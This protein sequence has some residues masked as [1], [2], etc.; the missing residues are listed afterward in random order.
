MDSFS[1]SSL[2]SSF[3]WHD[4]V[5]QHVFPLLGV[6]TGTFMS[7]AP[8]RAVLHATRSDGNLGDI[9]PTPWIFM[10]GNCCG[11]LT[12]SFITLNVYVFVTN[13]PG[14]ILSIWLNIQAI[15]LSYEN[16]RSNELQQAII[17]A[18]E[19]HSKKTLKKS[20]VE[21]I[22]TN[23]ITEEPIFDLSIID[24]AVT[25]PI[26]EDGV[27]VGESTDESSGTTTT[28]PSSSTYYSTETSSSLEEAEAAAAVAA[29]EVAEFKKHFHTYQ[30][31]NDDSYVDKNDNEYEDAN[32]FMDGITT[33]NEAA[34]MIVDYASFIWD[35]AAQKT[36]AP[37][38]HELMV[39]GIST[40]W[41]FLITVVVFTQQILDA[42]TRTLIIGVSVNLN[43]IFFYGAPLS[44]IVTV[45]DTKSSK[46]IHVPTMI[47]SLFNGTLWF[48]YG[49]AV[50][51]YFI[52]LPNGF[53]AML[54]VIQMIL[55]VLYP[56]HNRNRYH[57]VLSGDN[58]GIM[59]TK[60]QSTSSSS[61]DSLD[62]PEESTPLI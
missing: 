30:D 10:L 53:G 60:S 37:A 36:P 14:F 61:Y 16:Y 58:D 33:V 46:F 59:I 38:S 7:F 48:I 12:Y 57:S 22:V 35:I 43:L 47:T 18:L 2:S 9:N 41:L 20:D 32:T 21:K 11:W 50:H 39:V 40:L 55:C 62:L 29:S 51:D 26:V 27:G 28:P 56:R 15:K 6:V 4:V 31:S 52:A 45:I 17:A 19:D 25:A 42:S 23:V 8:Y 5:L 54:G 1:S 13:A 24:P 49:V 3:Q 34:E 44:K